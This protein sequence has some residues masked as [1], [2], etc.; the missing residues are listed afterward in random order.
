MHQF[1][2]SANRFTS[3]KWTDSFKKLK[4]QHY[5]N[6]RVS[7][8]VDKPS[9]IHEEEK[10]IPVIIV[11]EEGLTTP[12]LSEN[13]SSSEKEEEVLFDGDDELSDTDER[14]LPPLP[15]DTSLG[16]KRSITSS[17]LAI[18][19]QEKLKRA[20]T[21]LGLAS[22][23][24]MQSSSQQQLEKKTMK[25]QSASS[26]QHFLRLVHTASNNTS[27]NNFPAIVDDIGSYNSSSSSLVS[28]VLEQSL[29]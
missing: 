9:V 1:D 26:L 5:S 22:Q 29:R 14:P 8:L 20:A 4:L 10:P 6:K 27:Q 18:K 12:D 13:D 28:E 11:G 15:T 17:K 23:K 21:W 16:L 7:P 3:M 19:G 2:S 25:Y 24:V